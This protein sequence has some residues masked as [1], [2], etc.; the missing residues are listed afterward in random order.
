MVKLGPEYLIQAV[1]GV[2]GILL[3][4]AIIMLILLF[5]VSVTSIKEA[6][7]APVF[8]TVPADYP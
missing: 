4:L 3:I 6:V 5:E 8:A 2:M 7:V 1:Y